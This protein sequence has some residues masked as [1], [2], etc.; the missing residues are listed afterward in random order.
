VD[1]SDAI[2]SQKTLAVETHSLPALRR[3]ATPFKPQL[4][5]SGS[6]RRPGTRLFGLS[7]E[8]HARY[9]QQRDRELAGEQSACGLE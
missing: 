8:T 4:R 2:R 3:H 5:R 7:D 9:L 6:M 1:T